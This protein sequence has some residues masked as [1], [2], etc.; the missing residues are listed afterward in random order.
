MD[1][2]LVHGAVAEVAD[3]DPVFVAILDGEGD[4]GRQGDMA[5]DDGMAAEEALLRVEEVHRAA[6]PLGAA[7]HLAEQLGHGGLGVH[8]P[9]QG[10]AVV[11]IGGDHVVIFPEDPDRAHRNRLLAAVLVEES[12]DL[13]P[14]LVEHLRPL[15]EAADQ[16]HLAE[17][18]QCLG[19]VD[20]RFGLGLHLRHNHH[21]S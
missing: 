9:R 1:A 8:A 12:P 4:A 15:L 20:D 16:H 2:P 5:A 6:L 11:A 10:M 13:V 21:D 17:P 18:D 14:F 19:P 3:A 7:G